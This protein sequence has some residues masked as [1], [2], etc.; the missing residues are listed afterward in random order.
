MKKKRFC[1]ERELKMNEM[2]RK[3]ENEKVRRNRSESLWK[4]RKIKIEATD[5]IG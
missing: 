1:L 2:K 5:I 3:L 4:R